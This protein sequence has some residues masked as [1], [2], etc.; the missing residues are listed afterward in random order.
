MATPTSSGSS[1]RSA[2]SLALLLAAV[3]TAGAPASG[4]ACGWFE[5]DPNQATTFDPHVIGDGALLEAQFYDPYAEGFGGCEDCPRKEM[6]ADWAGYLGLPESAGWAKALFDA[7]VSTID[8]LIFF[9]QG[10]RPK[11]PAGWEASFVT[12]APPEGRERLVAALYL[13]GFARRVEPYAAAR[14]DGWSDGYGAELKRRM[15][16][17]GNPAALQASGDKALARARDAFL[18]Q[19]YAFLL[20][21]LRFHRQDW[22]GAI[23]FAEANAAALAGP[24]DGLRWRARYYVAGAHWRAGRYAVAN[25]ELAR[26]HA[27]FPPLAGAT[28][29]DF[30][31]MEEADWQATL[32]LAKSVREKTELWQMVG[33]TQ[34]AVA[35]IEAIAALDPASDLVELLAVRE[36]NRL[37]YR[38]VDVGPLERIAVRLAAAKRT[39]RPWLFE[40][41]AGHAAAL[42]GDLPAARA[43]LARAEK[44]AKDVPLAQ[45]QARASL[46]LALAK[47]WRPG[48]AALGE[49]LARL[50]AGVGSSGQAGVAQQRVRFIL[51]SACK[52]AG[53]RVEAELFVPTPA[54]HPAYSPPGSTAPWNDRAFVGALIARASAPKTDFD[55]FMVK[56]SGYTPA[57]L[58]AEL[59]MLHLSQGDL[60]DA[61]RALASLPEGSKLG[62]DPFVMHVVDCHDCDHEAYAGA[63]WTLKGFVSRLVALERKAGGKGEEA[64]KAAYELGAGT[65]N[66]TF[67]GNARVVLGQGHNATADTRLAERWFKR[68]FEASADRELKA[69]AATMAAKCELARDGGEVSKT[70]YPALR[71]LAGTAYEKEVLKECGW[72]REWRPGR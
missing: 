8:G 31:P 6:L 3:A 16:A 50:A 33:V 39:R 13:V 36:L 45:A 38:E 34:D 5:S 2:S 24:S 41:V 46:A 14:P 29:R 30:H 18:R 71:A 7:D 32:G 15:D 60:A 67:N 57:S 69:R 66:M 37:E 12:S 54:P 58:G 27:G 51:G 44:G 43:R 23:A 63:I 19:R 21:R 62:T 59:A 10:K 20:L 52:G 11:P 47:A 1:P 48:N 26:I 53:H 49:E 17:A 35:A 56:G 64:A 65:Y 40:L 55:R 25:V 4:R 72:Y 61:E 22:P 68:A 70:W 28:L 9:L 42:R